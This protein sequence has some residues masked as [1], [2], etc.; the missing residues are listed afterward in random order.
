MNKALPTH[1]RLFPETHVRGKKRKR[2]QLK[3]NKDVDVDNG[4]CTICLR[5]NSMLYMDF[6]SK[7]EM[8]VVEQPWLNVV[9]SFPAALER[10]VYG[11]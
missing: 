9:A 1:S 11:T 2:H 4:N 5:Y 6:I 3:D 8:L 7:N 10:K